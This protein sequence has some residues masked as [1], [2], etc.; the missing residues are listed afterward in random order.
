MSVFAFTV[1]FTVNEAYNAG[2]SGGPLTASYKLAQF[3]LHW[4]GPF[5]FQGSE[6]TLDGT[7]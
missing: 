5:K 1:K 7:Q 4:G 6:H 3:H 2:I